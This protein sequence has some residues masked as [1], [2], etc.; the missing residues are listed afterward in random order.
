MQMINLG[1]SKFQF[2]YEILDIFIFVIR[3]FL[4][5]FFIRLISMNMGSHHN[6]FIM[7]VYSNSYEWNEMEG[8][9][10]R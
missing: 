5:R 7:V 9:L 2:L 4:P 1:M 6:Y 10:I 8:I 3:T